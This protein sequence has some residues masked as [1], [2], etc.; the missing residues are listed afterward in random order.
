M[1][2]LLNEGG[3]SFSTTAE[4]EIAR[5]IKEKHCFIAEDYEEELDKYTSD[6]SRIQIDYVLPDGQTITLGSERFRCPEAILQPA[7]IGLEARG[8]HEQVH[9]AI[10]KCDVDVRS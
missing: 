4:L 8:M 10:N 1:A 6:P 5:D 7:L 9:R 3:N 2:A